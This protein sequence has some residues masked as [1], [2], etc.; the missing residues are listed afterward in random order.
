M[1]A[2]AS[3][4]KS[5]DGRPFEAKELREI[6]QPLL[7]YP[8]IALAVSGGSDSVALMALAS[9]WRGLVDDVQPPELVALSVDHGLRPSSATEAEWV[10]GEA[11]RLGLPHQILAWIGTKPAA[12]VQAAARS[13]RYELLI[14]HCKSHSIPALVT[15]HTL[16]DQAETLI[17]RL[18]RGSGLDGLAGI[19]PTSRREGLD[20]I[21]PLLGV[22]R[23]RLRRFLL[24]AKQGWIEDPSNLDARYERVRVRAALEAAERAGLSRAKLALSA[25]RLGRARQALKSATASYLAA[26]AKLHPAGFCEIEIDA[27]LSAPEEIALRALDKMT[28]A[29]GGRKGHAALAKIEAA[30][31]R[32]K[33]RPRPFTLAGCRIGLRRGCLCICREY[34]RMDHAATVLSPGCSLLWDGRFE[35]VLS[36]RAGK[37]MTLRPLGGDGLE[38][39][40]AAGGRWGA[41]PRMAAM[42][43]PSLWDG[44]TLSFVPFARFDE[45]EQPGWRELADVE[46]AN[47][48]LLG[49]AAENPRV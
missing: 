30:F 29:I 4:G 37:P 25:A 47:A 36:P 19:A 45:E 5:A 23:A 33:S 42:T 13:A 21:R 15:A 20:I 48:D 10:S 39:V 18:A 14:N 34:G 35:I 46:F 40:K 12:G 41:I 6:F 9:R 3:P 11:G 44:G 17:M 28:R 2:S 32:L 43:L 27:L 16:D 31:T 22:T 7:A 26:R 8:R 1:S 24:E 38:A 49:Q